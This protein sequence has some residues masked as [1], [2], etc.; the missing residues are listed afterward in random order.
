MA[1]PIRPAAA[2]GTAVAILA[3][4]TTGSDL[5]A[6]TAVPNLSG[7]YIRGDFVGLGQSDQVI[8]PELLTEEGQRRWLSYDYTTDD[9]AYGC[10]PSSWTRVWLNPNVVVRV[11]QADDHVRL[12]YEF[13]DLDRVIPL[14][15]DTDVED[16]GGIEG[17]PTLGRYVA[18]YDADTLVIDSSDYERGYISTIADW[19]GLPQSRRMR[20]I[21][22]ISRSDDGLTIEITH[23][24]PVVFRRPFVVTLN[25]ESTDF[26]LLEYGCVPEEA[27]IVAPD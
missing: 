27:S 12:R 22:R 19:A 9:P 20:T 14:V 15:A 13:M 17:L 6:Q 11:S 4:L 18:W 23:M 7:N 25:Y 5:A 10:I 21:E 2:L 1:P 3:G 16:A 8:D 26:E 24:D